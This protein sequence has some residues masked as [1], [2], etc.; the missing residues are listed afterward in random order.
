VGGVPDLLASGSGLLVNPGDPGELAAAVERV[1]GDPV[2]R[3]RLTLKAREE[4]GKFS[5]NTMA[6]RVLSVY[7]SCAHSLDGT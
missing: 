3:Q 6:E 7:R 2:L 4:V 1:L 5:V